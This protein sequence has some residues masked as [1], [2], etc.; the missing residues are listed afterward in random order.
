MKRTYSITITIE[1]QNK[2]CI[3]NY[4]EEELIQM[5]PNISSYIVHIV[6]SYL[7]KPRSETAYGFARRNNI[8]ES[9]VYKYLKQV[10]DSL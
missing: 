4:T 2:K 10:K 8:S 3:E 7:H 1:E 6:Y 9:L 5:L